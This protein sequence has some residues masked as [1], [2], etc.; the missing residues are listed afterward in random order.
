VPLDAFDLEKVPAHLRVTFAIEDAS[1]AVIAQ[2]KDLGALQAELAGPAR[3]AVA[4]VTG[5]E[6]D[7]LRDWPDDLDPLPDTVEQ[8]RGGH[9]VRGYPA[10]VDEERPSP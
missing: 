2:G 7:G 8:T 1:H 3:A 5:L 9:T 10:F 6:R 4:E